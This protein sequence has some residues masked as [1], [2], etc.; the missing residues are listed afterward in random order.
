MVAF[1]SFVLLTTLTT[2]VMTENTFI[3]PTRFS[4]LST[5]AINRIPSINNIFSYFAKLATIIPTLF[6]TGLPGNF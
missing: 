6:F 1:V 2:L 3:Q 5:G 4:H